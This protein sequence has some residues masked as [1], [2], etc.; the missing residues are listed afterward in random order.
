MALITPALNRPRCL[1][2]ELN[3]GVGL[4]AR[5]P[6]HKPQTATP[7]HSSTCWSSCEQRPAAAKSCGP[8]P[9]ASATRLTELGVVIED[10]KDGTTLAVGG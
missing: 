9:T 7:T 8:S 1:L 2:R 5:R 4:Q 6:L 10:N 3:R